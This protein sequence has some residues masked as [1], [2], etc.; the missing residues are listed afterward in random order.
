MGPMSDLGRVALVTGASGGIGAA[1]AE[2][3]AQAGHAVALVY[4]HGIEAA[5]RLADELRA[6]GATALTVAIDVTDRNSVDEGIATIEEE[7]GPV[8]IAVNNAGST[9]DALLMRMTDE[10]WRRP[11]ATSLDGTFHVTRRVVPAMLRARWGRIVNVSSVVG[12]T[13][14]AGQANYAT[15]KAGLVGFSRSLAREL[16]AR[17]VTVNVVAPGPIN[18]PMLDATGDARR[19][20]LAASVPLGRIGR[21][22]EVAAAVTYLCSEAAGYVTGA[23]LPVDGGLGMG[24]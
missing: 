18:T 5:D 4:H 24:H 6:G 1:V 9:A 16:A 22:S 17:Q 10:Q 21:P 2:G 11:L 23:V 15:A 14:S 3:L 20:E 12:L 8:A 19:I 13:G 7:L